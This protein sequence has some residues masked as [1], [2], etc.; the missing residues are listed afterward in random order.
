VVHIDKYERFYIIAVAVTLGVFFAALIAG[1]VVFGVRLPDAGSFINPNALS[2]TEF[3]N[4]GL[5]QVGTHRYELYIVA[6][7]WSFNVGS[8]E[9]DAVTGK[10]II[11][12]P[13]GSEVTFNITSS[14]VT[15]GFI[16]EEKNINMEVVP[17]HIGR[18]TTIFN[19]PGEYAV[20]CHEYC[21]R[22]HQT[23]YFKLIVEEPAAT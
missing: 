5:R 3:A 23:M 7:M 13:V 1:A 21:G 18:Q 11:R 19:Q 16:I 4:P 14:D 20:V 2:E 10:P 22:G 15:H 17:G 12:I 6:Q 9:I 8:T